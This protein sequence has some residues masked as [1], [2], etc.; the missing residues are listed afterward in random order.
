MLGILNVIDF[1]YL[2]SISLKLY[3]FILFISS[4]ERNTTKSVRKKESNKHS[5]Y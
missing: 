5:K 4:P 1:K 3:D 2:N